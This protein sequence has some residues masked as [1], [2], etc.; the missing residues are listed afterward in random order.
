[1]WADMVASFA[2]HADGCAEDLEE[3]FAKHFDD[4]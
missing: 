1:M 3:A 4:S 2:Q